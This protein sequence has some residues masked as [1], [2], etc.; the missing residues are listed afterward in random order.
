MGSCRC[1]LVV[2]AVCSETILLKRMWH[3]PKTGTRN[4]KSLRCHITIGWWVPCQLGILGG[5]LALWSLL[6]WFGGWIERT[7]SPTGKTCLEIDVETSKNSGQHQSAMIQLMGNDW[8]AYVS[9]CQ[10]EG[11]PLDRRMAA[12][13][14]PPDHCHVPI[15]NMPCFFGFNQFSNEKHQKTSKKQGTFGVVATVSWL[16]HCIMAGTWINIFFRHGPRSL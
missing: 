9:T 1:W 7:N 3:S 4:I 2:P 12:A 5:F 10:V 15:K 11:I 14:N 6:P 13:P 16:E 8:L